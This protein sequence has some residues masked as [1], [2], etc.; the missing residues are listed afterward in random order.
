MTGA[1]PN[2]L[3]I[4]PLNP[5][6]PSFQ[7]YYI[8]SVDSRLGKIE[9]FMER[10]EPVIQAYEQKSKFHVDVKTGSIMAGITAVITLAFSFVA[11]VL[12]GG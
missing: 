12:W 11:Y 1:L 8:Q 6:D 7:A 2:P 10:A 3:G 4:P 5:S 9:G